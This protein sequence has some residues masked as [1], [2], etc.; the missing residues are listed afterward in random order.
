MEKVWLKHYPSQVPHDIQV[1]EISVPQ[2]LTDSAGQFPQNIALTFAPTKA[3]MSYWE[4]KEKTNFFAGALQK[5]GIKK[6]PV[7][8]MLP[9]CF[10]A[11]IT[12]FGTLSA[13]AILVPLNP[14]YTPRELQ[15]MLANSGAETIVCLEEMFPMVAQIKDTPLRNIITVRMGPPSGE[16]RGIPFHRLIAERTCGEKVKIT[17]GDLAMIQYTAG[18]TGVPKGVMITHRNIVTNVIQ[19]SKFCWTMEPGK[20]T[21]V[22]AVPPFHVAGLTNIII[23]G[24]FLG[25][26]LV[27]LPKF[28]PVET[29]RAITDYRSSFFFGVPAMYAALLKIMQKGGK[30]EKFEF[31]KFSAIGTAPCPPLLFKT[32]KEIFPELT[33]GYGLTETTGVCFANPIG[34]LKK[35]GSVGI[36]FPGIELRIVDDSGK[37]LKPR[38]IGEILI[39]GPNIA[40]GYWKLPKETEE[41]F[42]EGWLHTGDVGFVDEDGYLFLVDRKK[43][44]INVRGEKVSSREIEQVLES[45]PTIVEAAVVGVPD[46]YWGEK[47]VAFVVLGGPTTEK[48]IIEYCKRYLTEYKLPREIRVVDSLPR[49]SVGKVLKEKL[50]KMAL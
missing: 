25:A 20:E 11:V 45:N 16:E 10:E 3:K 31:L 38:E 22:V 15:Y 27:L 36:P 7:A 50:R 28:D 8:M 39:R 37:E 33:E 34:G 6:G 5:L 12:L 24:I 47:I 43:D 9:N 1:P 41:T 40:S 19:I 46:P 21:F 17:P 2:I 49:S 4:L 14:Q 44:I 48:E 42:K 23:W 26:T 30:K 13:G 32:L 29:L 18:T 35:E